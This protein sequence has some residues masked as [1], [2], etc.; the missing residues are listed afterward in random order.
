M[1]LSR[2][3]EWAKRVA[4]Q[5]NDFVVG[6]CDVPG[7][8]IMGPRWRDYCNQE[9][10]NKCTRLIALAVSFDSLMDMSDGEICLGAAISLPA[11]ARQIR[12]TGTAISEHIASC[13]KCKNSEYLRDI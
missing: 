7:E 5:L 2:W 10:Q 13:D 4:E 3:I 6:S 11:A 9:R 12:R 8:G 1:A